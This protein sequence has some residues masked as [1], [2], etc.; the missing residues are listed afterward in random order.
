MLKNSALPLLLILSFFGILSTSAQEL[1]LNDARELLLTKN[2][3]YNASGYNIQQKEEE[4][5][6]AKG[7]HLPTIGLSGNYIHLQDDIVI[8]LNAQRNQLA[9]IL[10]APDPAQL[11][12][13]Q[14]TIQDQNFGFASA[15]F[16]MP[17][18]TGG[19]INAANKAAEIKLNL[20]EEEHDIQEEAL[21]I[22]LVDYYYQL[23]LALQMEKLRESVLN[24]VKEHETQAKKLFKNGMI[25]EVETLN[26][27]VALSNA[28]RNLK[29]ARKDVQLAKTALKNL[30]GSDSFD[31]LTTD[32]HQPIILE[33]LEN[34]QQEMLQSNKKL[35]VLKENK[36][37]AKV[38][39]QVE[40]SEYFPQFAALGRYSVWRDNFAL[41]QT[42]WMVGVGFEW[43]L[44][45]G[46]QRE[47]KIKAARHKIS[48]VE[49]LETQAKL[50]LRTYTV[51]LYNTMQ[52][53]KEQYDSLENDQILAEKLKYMRSRAFEEG[54]GTSLELIDATLKL[55]EIELHKM[56]ALYEFNKA[57]AELMLNLG[58]SNLIFSQS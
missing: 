7:L 17:L 23:K 41:S 50:D 38:G 12:N 14:S 19:K 29:A 37:L 22:K 55:S 16:K 10:Q 3:K 56:K 35:A 20:A 4:R 13:W 48:Y 32:F 34:Y 36:S 42:D 5:L 18:F 31:T 8:D 6:A 39:V 26:A 53:E 54:M 11:G 15:N 40:K 46:L 47:H 51:K 33:T 30:I 27:Q 44:F 45:D 21:S 24:T 57:Y 9:G 25:P 28:T 52:K 2:G 43:K 58:K 1:S 49:A